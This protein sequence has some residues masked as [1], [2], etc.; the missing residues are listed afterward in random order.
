M[1][2]TARAARDGRG[3]QGWMTGAARDGWQGRPGTAGLH[4]RWGASQ[5]LPS[6]RAFR[7]EPHTSGA[8]TSAPHR[9]LRPAQQPCQ[10]PAGQVG[11]GAGER[12]KGAAKCTGGRGVAWDGSGCAGSGGWPIQEGI[13]PPRHSRPTPPRSTNQPSNRPPA[14]PPNPPTDQLPAGLL[15][16][17]PQDGGGA[18]R[19]RHAGRGPHRRAPPA[20]GVA[21]AQH[22]VEPLPLHHDDQ[23]LRDANRPQPPRARCVAPPPRAH[24]R[25]RLRRACLRHCS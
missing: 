8:H 4:P 10:E 19:G 9:H 16:A 18:G 24:L 23:L 5:A 17:W 7:L 1:A 22:R 2:G 15:R 13:L 6:C 3:G 21:R 14:Q 20:R 11:P 12:G 25:H